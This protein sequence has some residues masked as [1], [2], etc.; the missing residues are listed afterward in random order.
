MLGAVLA[1]SAACS[2]KPQAGAPGVDS[3]PPAPAAL[4]ASPAADSVAKAAADSAAKSMAPAARPAGKAET[5]DYDK[6]I[7]PKFRI[8]E[9][10]GK[11]D[12]IRRP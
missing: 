11:I 5:G 6:A 3:T 10:T 2:G 9:K 4:P 7:R 8:D 1:L 12:T